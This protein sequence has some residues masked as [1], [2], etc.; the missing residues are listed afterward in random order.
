MGM[1]A[2]A[3]GDSSTAPQYVETDYT[4]TTLGDSTFTA[5]GL[6]NAGQIVGSFRAGTVPEHVLIDHGTTTDLGPCAPDGIN[7]DGVIACLNGTLWRNG[8]TTPLPLPPNFVLFSIGVNDQ[9]VVAGAG[10]TPHSAGDS[11]PCSQGCAFI[12][13]S[14]RLILFPGLA[15]GFLQM[16]H[17]TDVLIG[18]SIWKP[19][20]TSTPYTCA[21]LPANSSAYVWGGDHE[22]IGRTAETKPANTLKSDAFVC[23]G[24]A[25]VSLG[26]ATSR[27]NDISESGLIVGTMDNGRGFL[28]NN[29]KLT[30][31]GR[32]GEYTGAFVTDAYRVNDAG[33]IVVTTTVGQT[34][35]LTPK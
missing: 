35:L 1:L 33:Q 9:G 21:G 7:D 28:W 20:S 16:T 12:A 4:V 17:G 22:V 27:A 32:I 29:G 13:A 23:R 19:D 10:I 26:S 31:L 5:T 14:G 24:G 25:M 30:V 15:F 8:T 6:N 3:C 18:G 11:E 2:V 34:L